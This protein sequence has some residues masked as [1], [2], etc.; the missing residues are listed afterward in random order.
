V[1]RT[2]ATPSANAL[3]VISEIR[4][5]STQTTTVSLS[6]WLQILQRL[7]TEVFNPSCPPTEFRAQAWALLKDLYL[8]RALPVSETRLGGTTPYSWLQAVCKLRKRSDALDHSLLAFS[9]VQVYLAETGNATVDEGLQLYNYA[10]QELVKDLENGRVKNIE[11]TLAAI[12]VLSTCEVCP[13][14]CLSC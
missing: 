6:A 11:E 13:S 4:H 9:A 10:L 1:N 2:L 14:C 3:S 8:P 5:Q 7:R 12:V